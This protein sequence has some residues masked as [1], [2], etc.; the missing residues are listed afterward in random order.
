MAITRQASAASNGIKLILKNDTIKARRSIAVSSSL[1]A[2]TKTKSSQVEGGK[3]E[4]KPKISKKKATKPTPTWEYERRCWDIPGCGRVCGVDE[5]GRGPLAGP[6][7]AGACTFTQEALKGEL[8]TVL[9]GLQDSKKLT[10]K[11][12]ETLYELLIVHPGIEWAACVVGPREIDAVNI[13]QASLRAM[14]RAVTSLPF[15]P[16]AILVDGNKV[17]PGLPLGISQA[18]VKGDAKCNSVAA[19]SIIAKVT[20]TD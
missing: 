15:A 7:V 5:A 3:L 14:E 19:A 18:V 4:K 6:V 9:S 10:E 20:G 16:D 13:L 11:Q 12:R 1:S 8:G 17:P 2:S